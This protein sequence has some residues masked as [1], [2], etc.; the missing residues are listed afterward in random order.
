MMRNF[1]MSAHFSFYEMTRTDHRD[2]LEHNREAATASHHMRA[3]YALVWSL[4]EPIRRHYNA[5]LI[6]HSGFRYPALN[7]RVGG[8]PQSQHVLFA[9]CDFHVVGV[10][11]VDVFHWIAN[12]PWLPY[13]QAILEN[14]NGGDPE[15]IHIGLGAPYRNEATRRLLQFD[16]TAYV[17]YTKAA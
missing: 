12:R 13:G 15:A 17:P 8:A 2:L 5:P 9:A 6:P 16:G 1:Q 4:L 7:E 11:L 10:S 3:G 14:W